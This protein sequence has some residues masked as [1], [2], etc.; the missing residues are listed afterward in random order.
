[1]LTPLLA[2]GQVIG[3]LSVQ[4]REPGGLSSEA[5]GWV[6]QVADSISVAI[7]SARLRE[8]IEAN[9]AQLQALSRRM[10]ER[11]ERERSYVADRLYNEAAQVIAAL[12]WQA[13]L[14]GRSSQHDAAAVQ[15]LNELTGKMDRALV[16]LHRLASDL[17]PAVL[18]RGG[19]AAAVEQYAE[20]FATKHAVE[21]ACRTGDLR[22][23]RL[24]AETETC[25]YRVLQEALANVAQHAQAGHVEVALT[26]EAGWLRLVV[27]DD[28]VG[29]D[30][31]DV[32]E[33]GSLG[34]VGM[35]ERA[36]AVGGWLQIESRPG[37]GTRITLQI[38]EGTG[39]TGARDIAG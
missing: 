37:G 35:S 14:L 33:R 25:A 6:A 27:A 2:H 19:L 38:P 22:G 34:F 29:F 16:E 13:T 21:V 24:P 31:Q 39:T 4:L 5:A 20:E 30:P 9:Q 26:R 12:K 7:Q 11:Q 18:D 3:Q 10:V 1:M 28:G 17:R 36:D 15:W 23:V 8:R 32:E